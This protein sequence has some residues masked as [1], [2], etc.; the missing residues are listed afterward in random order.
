M[1]TLDVFK[2]P[3][4]VRVVTTG[5]AAAPVVLDEDKRTN[6]TLRPAWIDGNSV[7]NGHG[8]CATPGAFWGEL[9]IDRT[10][11]HARLAVVADGAVHRATVTWPEPEVVPPPARPKRRRAARS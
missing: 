4:E 10:A 8:S 6:V 7:V 11:D 5:T 2:M 9:P 3:D 1:R